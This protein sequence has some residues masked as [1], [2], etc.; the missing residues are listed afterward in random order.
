MSKGWLLFWTA[1]VIGGSVND[2][3]YGY[4]FW[5]VFEAIVGIG[6]GVHLIKRFLKED[7]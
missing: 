5:S 1:L 7:E 3:I 6:S 2:F 4:Y